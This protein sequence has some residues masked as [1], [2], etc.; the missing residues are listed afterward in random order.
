MRALLAL[1]QHQDAQ[2]AATEYLR[3]HPSGASA[4]TARR[5]LEKK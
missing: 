2:R 3:R 5:I 4:A 1:G